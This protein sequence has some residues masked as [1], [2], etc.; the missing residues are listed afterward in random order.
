MEYGKRLLPT[1]IDQYAKE[2][3]P[4]T[5]ASVPKSDD[6]LSLGFVD[7][8]YEQFANAINRAAWWLEGNLGKSDKT[9]QTFG[10]FGPRDLRYPILIIAAIK[11]G[12]KI[13]VPSL[14]ASVD[15]HLSLVD[16]SCCETFLC[17]EAMVPMVEKLLGQRTSMKRVLV[18]ELEKWLE[19]AKVREY[20]YDKDYQDA[21]DDPVV[22]VHTS[23][24]SGLP[25]PVT[26]TNAMHGVLD[27]YHLLPETQGILRHSLQSGRRSYSPLPIFHA[28]GIAMAL[29]Y[30]VFWD[31][32]LVLGPARKPASA[33]TADQVHEYGNVLCG[34]YPPALLE[35]LV[36]QPNLHENLKKL[37][38][39]RWGGAPLDKAT[40]DWLAKHVRPQAIIGSTENGDWPSIES[41]PEDWEYFHFHQAM[42]ASFEHNGDDL[43]ELIIVRKPEL[44]AYQT[45]FIAYP[46]LCHCSTKDLWRKHPTKADHWKYVGRT[47][48]LVVLTGE[49]KLYPTNM[50]KEL[51]KH[52][53]IRSALI[54]GQGKLRPFVLLELAGETPASEAERERSIEKI[55]SAVEAAN[56]LC[57]EKGRL[58]RPLVAIAAPE[59]PFVKI[60][61]GTL[62]RRATIKLYEREVKTLYEEH[63]GID[64]VDE[65]TNGHTYGR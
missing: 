32:I 42:G 57:A 65:F 8:S 23:G 47:D 38:V 39:V 41:S 40:G 7:I 20:A 5:Y 16:L 1:L 35:E 26:F 33:T 46:D 15:A 2:P 49:V 21:K 30:T 28:V 9:F 53:T 63:P 37:D 22:I 59:K 52:E 64:K 51:E 54:G 58:T 3:I 14:L 34:T 10:Y 43:Y 6:D 50:E 31:M 18:P 36:R 25:K 4:R 27:A 61:K 45:V 11:I 48:D 62:D 60:W 12:W 19:G 17:D 55:W 24:T 29:W 56:E 44:A 13:L